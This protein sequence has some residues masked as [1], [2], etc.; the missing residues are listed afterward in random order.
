MK[1]LK[2]LIIT[3]SNN[4]LGDT[5]NKT[6]VWLEDLAAPYYV[7]K[8]GGEFITLVSP[9]GGQI[10]LDP[11]SNSTAVATED[12][13]RFRQDSQAMYHL[14]HSL[15]INEVNAEDFDLVFLSGGYGAM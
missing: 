6:G 9:K 4:K 12:T 2:S 10:P 3:T 13:I 8:D 15:P 7:L 5:T 14:S 11:N 1:S